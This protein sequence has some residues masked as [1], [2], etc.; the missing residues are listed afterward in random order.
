[1]YD[2]YDIAI[3]YAPENEDY[4]SA[5][6]EKIKSLKVGDD[7]KYKL[8]F[9]PDNEADLLGR[10]LFTA[11]RKVYAKKSK[12]VI[13]L[14]SNDYVTENWTNHE[15]L[16]IFEKKF[17]KQKINNDECFLFLII[18]EE[19]K[20]KGDYDNFTVPYERYKKFFAKDKQ[21]KIIKLKP[22]V[23]A[24]E[25]I[26]ILDKTLDKEKLRAQQAARAQ[27]QAQPN[28]APQVPQQD[29]KVQQPQQ[30]S[31]SGGAAS[32][33]SDSSSSSSLLLDISGSVEI[34]NS[35]AYGGNDGGFIMVVQ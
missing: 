28:P 10:N 27:S 23:A 11:L 5:I 16:A 1:M 4:A 7:Q 30:P 19:E 31:G 13:A 14:L 35:N 3:S 26:T 32:P 22:E 29:S 34:K 6:A 21:D 9:A 15:M 17:D 8:F 20:N 25:F 12:Y 2:W 33:A 18:I 24:H